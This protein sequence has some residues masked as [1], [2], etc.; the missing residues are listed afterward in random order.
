[1]E[2]ALSQIPSTLQIPVYYF[3]SNSDGVLS[4]QRLGGSIGLRGI[5]Y[6]NNSKSA[7]LFSG[8]MTPKN[9]TD[10]LMGTNL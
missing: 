6:D 8:S 3:D 5:V 2:D 7:R 1:M 10:E 4:A 9:I